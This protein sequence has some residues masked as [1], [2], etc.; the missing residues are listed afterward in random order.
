MYNFNRLPEKGNQL[1]KEVAAEHP[2][3]KT[4]HYNEGIWLCDQMKATIE[5]LGLSNSYLKLVNRAIAQLEYPEKTIAG[6]IVSHI[7]EGLDLLELGETLGARHKAEILAAES[8]P[9]FEHLD[10]AHQQ[11]L[12]SILQLGLDVPVEYIQEVHLEA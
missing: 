8:L 3:S 5:E 2:F 1:T 6:R 4:R 7:E 11:H 10:P 9:G 12:V